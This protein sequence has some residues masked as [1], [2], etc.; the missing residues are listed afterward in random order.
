MVYYANISMSNMNTRN[1][2]STI[3]QIANIARARQIALG[4][5]STL[6]IPPDYIKVLLL[7]ISFLK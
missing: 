5:V 7:K 6:K 3:G 1:S 4:Y 2:K